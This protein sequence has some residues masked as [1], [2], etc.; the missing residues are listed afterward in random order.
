VFDSAVGL[1]PLVVF[2]LVS[3]LL[4]YQHRL[5]GLPAYQNPQHGDAHKGPV[6]SLIF[7]WI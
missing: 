4:P 6:C 7:S 1:R 3:I 5:I 2:E